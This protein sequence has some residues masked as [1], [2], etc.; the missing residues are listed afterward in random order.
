MQR[1]EIKLG[2]AFKGQ[3]YTIT[4]ILKS[5][6]KFT[7]LN[8][9]YSG[10]EFP[11]IMLEYDKVKNMYKVSKLRAKAFGGW[12][13]DMRVVCLTPPLP[14]K[15]A[16][17]L[18]VLTSLA[19]IDIFSNG[20]HPRVRINDDAKVNNEYPLSWLKFFTSIASG[21]KPETTYSKY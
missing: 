20:S 13:N 21:R 18:L 2:L 17:D 1:E 5:D 10:D 3:E 4:G 11:C 9:G 6:D 19:I 12:T 15:G 16:L 8:L 14:E 7:R